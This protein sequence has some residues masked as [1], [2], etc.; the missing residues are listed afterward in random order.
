[1]PKTYEP[2]ATQTLGTATGNVNFSS[3]PQTYTDLILVIQPHWNGG[4]AYN[5]QFRL[6]TDSGSNYSATVLTGNGASASSSRNSNM[7][8][9][10]IDSNANPSTT[11]GATTQIMQIM[12][13][14]NTTTN[15]T[16]IVRANKASTGTDLIVNL[17]RSTAAITAVN[18]WTDI[19]SRRNDYG[20]GSTFTLYGVKS[21]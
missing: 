19:N 20:V 5:T 15:K 18:L 11:A 13:Y 17:W 4:T 3:I 7:T 14:S 8:A 6:N 2:I 12:N 10:F 9:G 21:A 16:V 1:M